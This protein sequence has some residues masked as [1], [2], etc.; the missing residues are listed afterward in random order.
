M[1]ANG[2]DVNATDRLGDTAL[3]WAAMSGHATIVEFLVSNGADVNARNQFRDTPL[4][5]AAM[6]GHTAIVEI[7]ERAAANQPTSPSI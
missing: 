1:L 2:A 4:H 6:N 3:H 7:V 5:W